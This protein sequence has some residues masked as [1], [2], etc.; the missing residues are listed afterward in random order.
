MTTLQ[1]TIRPA[2]GADLARLGRIDPQLGEA[3]LG[4]KAA[5]LLN[6][7]RSLV[8]DINGAPIAYAMISQD[9]F[10]RPLLERIV[11][12]EPYRRRGV[13]L[14]LLARCETAHD[15]DR[16]FVTVKASDAPMLGMLAK[17]GFQGS[18]VIYNLGSSD[19]ELV[20]VRLRAPPLTFIKYQPEG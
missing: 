9:F 19:P 10:A 18:G 17:A 1:A 16:M 6:N 15:D 5:R 4:R 12:A 3:A 14:A 11:V 8:A 13:G 7:G 20:Y 2:W